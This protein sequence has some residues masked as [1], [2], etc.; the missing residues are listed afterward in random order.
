MRYLKQ[1]VMDS[2]YISS[3]LA[4][5]EM[6]TAAK[7]YRALRGKQGRSRTETN[8]PDHDWPQ[9]WK[10]LSEKA[11]PPE[12]RDTWYKVVHNKIPTNER[13]AR[14][15]MRESPHCEVCNEI[16]TA[17]HRF[18]C[19]TSQAIWETCRKMVALMNRADHRTIEATALTIPAAKGF[20]RPK[21]VATMW[22]FAMTAHAIIAK[23]QTDG[24]QFLTDLW[25]EHKRAKR[26]NNYRQTF[27]NYLQI[28]LDAAFKDA[29][30]P[31]TPRPPPT[32]PPPPPPPLPPPPPP[33]P[34]AP[35]PP[36]LPLPPPSPPTLPP[37]PTPPA[38]PTPPTPL[39][40]HHAPP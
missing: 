24:V 35:P 27:Q 32:S 38:P 8:L 6:R 22:T 23:K 2:S 39:P 40:P 37:P 3:T 1:I 36:P 25:E 26:K 11:I 15:A 16:D 13:L 10:N 17:E 7:I 31:H 19:P 33:P 18:T 5:K 21:R 4:V 12:A 14:I 30:R 9:V 29:L 20:P 28:A 34:P